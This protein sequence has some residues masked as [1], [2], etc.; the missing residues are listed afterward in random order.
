[1]QSVTPPPVPAPTCRPRHDVFIWA[2]KIRTFTFSVCD[3]LPPRCADGCRWFMG[4]GLAVKS[5][6]RGCPGIN[7]MASDGAVAQQSQT[8]SP[9]SLSRSNRLQDL[10]KRHEGVQWVLCMMF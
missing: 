1:M 2:D 3:A 8:P 10:V 7:Y 9:R 5:P 6:R 4:Q